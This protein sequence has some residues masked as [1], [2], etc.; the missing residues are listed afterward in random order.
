MTLPSFLFD[1]H[2]RYKEETNRVVTW[3]VETAQKCGFLPSLETTPTRQSG[4]LK[5]KARKMAREKEKAEVD[6]TIASAT[7]FT[8]TVNHFTDLADRIA[9]HKPRVKVPN[10]IL[11]LVRSA[12]TQRKRCADWFHKRATTEE[13][14]IDNSKHWHF[15]SVLELVLKILEPNSVSESTRSNKAPTKNMGAAKKSGKEFDKSTNIYDVLYIDDEDTTATEGNP[16]SSV[17]SVSPNTPPPSTNVVYELETTEEEAFFALFCIF[18]DLN[19]LRRFLSDLWRDYAA[20]KLN[21]MSVSVTTNLA[22]NLVRRAE[23]DLMA[24]FPTLKSFD[25]VSETFNAVMSMIKSQHPSC[26]ENDA[27]VALEDLLYMSTHSAMKF[28][29]GLVKQK[30]PVFLQRTG[31]DDSTKTP[32][33]TTERDRMLEEQIILLESLSEFF[34]LTEFTCHTPIED[35]LTNGL[36]SAFDDNNVPLFLAFAAQTFVDIYTILGENVGRGLSELQAS[37]IQIASTILEY[38]SNTPVAFAKCPTFT[39]AG[40]EKVD[41]FI[42]DWILKDLIGN[43][44]REKFRDYRSVPQEPHALLKRHPLLCG[45]FQF[46]LSTYLRYMSVDLAQSWGTILYVAYLYEACRRAGHLK[47]TWPDM[48]LV[49]NIHTR[50]RMFAGRIPQTSE[51]FLKCMQLTLGMSLASFSRSNRAGRTK[52]V[53]KNRRGLAFETPVMNVFPKQWDQPGDAMLTTSTVGDLLMNPRY[54]ST[55]EITPSGSEDQHL[56]KKESMLQKQ[57]EKSHTLTPLQLLDTVCNAI[58]DEEAMVRFDYLSLHTRCL[59]LLSA[60]RTVIDDQLR[61]RFGEHYI[62]GESQL[63]YVIYCIFFEAAEPKRSRENLKPKTLLESSMLKKASEVVRT[64][65]E[66]EGSVECDKLEKTC[67]YWSKKSALSSDLRKR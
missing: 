16:I 8:V 59:R 24:T 25:D 3:L 30:M 53:N 17:R 39:A 57:W 12:I 13:V 62:D 46:K 50:E 28:Y 9:N 4:R 19:Q 49:M 38:R 63:C 45:L 64:Y 60:V 11:S 27:T 37:A 32:R 40:I 5:G 55:L 42:G 67:V 22:I 33:T 65:I 41:Q 29:C 47:E 43:M 51:E 61:D 6:E 58:F 1:S 54:A 20:R 48:E 21:L 31:I 18:E 10:L 15:I 34:C 26:K 56:T 66:R 35:E 44:K 14:K 2:K 7:R 36:R 52:T 23:Q